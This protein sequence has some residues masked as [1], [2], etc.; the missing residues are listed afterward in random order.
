MKLIFEKSQPGR[1]S[2]A[3]FSN[4]PRWIARIFL[5]IYC[6]VR[7]CGYRNYPSWKSCGIIRDYQRAIFQSTRI[8]IHWVRVR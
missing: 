7:R 4:V 1:Y 6:G 5:P 2:C 3:H 8:F